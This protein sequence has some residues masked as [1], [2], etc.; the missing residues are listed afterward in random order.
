M[1]LSTALPLAFVLL[2]AC[3]DALPSGTAKG[4]TPAPG[5]YR[6]ELRCT[7][8]VDQPR[9]TCDGDAADGAGPRRSLIVGGQ[10]V[11]VRLASS[12][13]GYNPS[14]SIF[15]VDV[16]VQ[17]LMAQA[18][19]TPD[20]EVKTG[21][22][23]FF[24]SG[25]T[26]VGGAGSVEV[27]N[28]DGQAVFVAAPAPYFAYD[29]L[30]Y[31][32]EIS[33]TKAWRFKMDP[34]VHR[35]V[36]TVYVQGELPHEESILLFRPQ[37]EPDGGLPLGL[38]GASATEVFAA[39]FFGAV[40]RYT[41]GTW[42]ADES[43]TDEVLWDVWGSSATDVFAVGDAGTIV[44][45]DGTSWSAMASGLEPAEGECGCEPT[46]I[47]AVWGSGPSNVY[48]VADGGVVLHYDGMAW[49]AQDTLPVAGLYGVWG[50]GPS[51]VFAAGDDGGIFHYDGTSWT[52]MASGLEGTGE[53]LNM[54]WGLSPTDVYAAAS[55]GVLHY[56]GTSW[57][58]LAGARECEHI[59]VWGSAADDLFVVN[60]CGIDH[61]NGS[62]WAYMDSGG[63]VTEVWG[64][65]P[66]HV[67]TNT[68]GGIFRGSR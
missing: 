45:W 41:G 52:A 62:T 64:T 11:Y 61:W 60:Q 21:L 40:M 29:T 48:A 68:N 63:F 53:Y 58:P 19:G 46:T 18:F 4:P 8:D 22:R 36:F 65:G 6:A 13:A 49:A 66:H 20:G 16:S 33:D 43:P 35:F 57:S 51:D 10:H 27:E 38:W 55:N 17:N 3:S 67:L 25:P 32:G 50:S 24:E 5:S 54:V 7:V 34:E 37:H 42:V 59:S 30:L 1:R 47:W 2:A 31:T 26:P 28:A 39:G 15:Q 12:G 9:L 23:V 56:D 44:H 14:D